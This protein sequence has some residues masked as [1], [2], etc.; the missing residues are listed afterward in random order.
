MVIAPFRKKFEFSVNYNEKREFDK[1]NVLKQDI[2]D[3]LIFM[4]MRNSEAMF[5]NS[6]VGN[7]LRLDCKATIIDPDGTLIDE[8]RD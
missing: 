4:R 8:P 3:C 6:L 5:Y 1:K 7:R 2:F